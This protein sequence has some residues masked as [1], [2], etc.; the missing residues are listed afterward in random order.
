MIP[1]TQAGYYYI[2]VYQSYHS[3]LYKFTITADYPDEFGGASRE[4]FKNLLEDVIAAHNS[5]TSSN[6]AQAFDKAQAGGK[7]GFCFIATA[8][9]G[10]YLDP[11][12]KVLRDFRD[13]YLIADFR[14]QILDL[15]IEIPNIIGKSFVA[16]YYQVSPP[17]ADYI[18][19]HE[20]LR[21][22]T[23]LV[24]TP[25]IYGIKYPMINLIPLCLVVAIIMKRRKLL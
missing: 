10:S 1:N 11:H 17:I 24:L 25:V 12:V 19:Q 6:K 7:G 20:N 23:R 3:G 5:E 22:V 2:L 13:K 4:V 16:I 15:K 21:I 9:Y 14:L 18:S 8:A